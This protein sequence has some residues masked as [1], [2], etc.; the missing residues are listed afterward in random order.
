MGVKVTGIREAK[1]KLNAL[2][3]DI[4]GRKVVRAMYKALYIGS[5]QAALYTP[6]DTA[7]LIN[8]QFRDVR[9]D[10]VR[11][12]GRVGYSANYAVYVH[13]PKVKQNFRRAT[14][15]K[16]FLKRGFNEVRAQIDKA[17]MEEL[18]SL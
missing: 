3:G 14:A 15:K 9:F 16:E 4:R 10:G 2:I 11:L 17:V 7:T 12:T 5:A 13:D 8:S 1:T 18:K 6:I